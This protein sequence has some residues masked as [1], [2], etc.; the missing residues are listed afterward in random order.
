MQLSDWRTV[1]GVKYPYVR[2]FKLNDMEVQR[3]TLK[4]VTPNATLA[5]DT[6]AIPDAVKAA[7]N[8]AAAS[9][10]SSLRPTCRWSRAA[11]PTI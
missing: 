1:A 10:W 7:G 3:I 2:S 5:P 4:E 8:P 11:A 6:F 9:S